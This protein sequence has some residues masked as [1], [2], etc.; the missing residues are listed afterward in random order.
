MPI[1]DIVPVC[2]A[3][4]LFRP[5]SE[6]VTQVSWVTTIID[7]ANPGSNPP[8]DIEGWQEKKSGNTDVPFS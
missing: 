3:R 1:T 7:T 2:Q 6:T 4:D 8:E 5:E